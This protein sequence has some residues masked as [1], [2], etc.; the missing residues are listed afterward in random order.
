MEIQLQCPW[1]LPLIYILVEDKL[2]PKLQK[3]NQSSKIIFFPSFRK[4]IVFSYRLDK[5]ERGEHL[6]QHVALTVGDFIGLFEKELMIPCED[7]IVV[8]PHYELLTHQQLQRILEEG[9]QVTVN[10]NRLNTTLISGIRNYVPGDKMSWVHWKATARKNEL[11]TKKFEELAS[12]DAFIVLDQTTS[13]LF[14]ERINFVASVVYSLLQKGVAVA[15][16][17][18]NRLQQ[19]P[20]FGRGSIQKEKIL[21]TL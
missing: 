18:T 9:N 16:T 13:E 19:P 12:R 1:Y 10:H 4:Q 21:H 6:F 5:L 7:R 2:S 15:Y 14:E 11:M 3:G 8:Y 17:N 20:L